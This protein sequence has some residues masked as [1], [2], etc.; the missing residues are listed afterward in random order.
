MSVLTKFKK[1]FALIKSNSDSTSI[2]TA[3][4][5]AFPVSITAISCFLSY[6]GDI[7]HLKVVTHVVLS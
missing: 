4:F 2:T 5:H 7:G 3:S 1:I 6:Y